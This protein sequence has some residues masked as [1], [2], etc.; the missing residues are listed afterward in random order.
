MIATPSLDGIKGLESLI[1]DAFACA[2]KVPKKGEIEE[3]ED[4]TRV[5]R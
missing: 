2:P 3:T 4:K 5:E 1:W